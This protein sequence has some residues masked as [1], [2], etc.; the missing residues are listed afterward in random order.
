MDAREQRIIEL[1]KEKDMTAYEV[2]TNLR[3][4]SENHLQVV[5]GEVIPQLHL[6]EKRRYIKSYFWEKHSYRT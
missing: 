6:L 1:V 3:L 5:P 4:K 2:I